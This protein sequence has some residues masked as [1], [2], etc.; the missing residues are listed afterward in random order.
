MPG[1]F[2]Q[3]KQKR[4]LFRVAFFDVWLREPDLN[5]RPSGYE[6]DELPD[7]SIPRLCGGILQPNAKVSTLNLE[8]R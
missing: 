3:S 8:R 7:C 6:P 4:P 1:V 2:F 5:R